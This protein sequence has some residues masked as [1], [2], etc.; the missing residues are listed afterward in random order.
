MQIRLTRKFADAIDGIDLSR[1]YVGELIE[2]PR[3]DGDM[4][5]AEG[6]ASPAP[7]WN[8]ARVV[9][10]LRHVREQMGEPQQHRRAEDRIREEHQDSHSRT[11]ERLPM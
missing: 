8:Q 10:H 3:H 5:I 1:H 6:W 4:L 7:T 9:E 2:L 11:V